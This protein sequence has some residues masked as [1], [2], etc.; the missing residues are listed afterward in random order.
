MSDAAQTLARA[1]APF[2]EEMSRLRPSGSQ[3]V[4]AHAHLGRDEDGREL[5]PAT[6]REML[7]ADDVARAVVFALH[8]PERRPAYSLP[9]DRVL[10][11]AGESEG[12]FVPF[13][14]LDPAD[15]PIAEAERCLERGARGFKLHPRAQAFGFGDGVADEIFALA[16]QAGVPILIHAGRGMPPIADGLA[17]LALRYP[18]APLILAHGAIADQ[19]V[20]TTRLAGHPSVLY[21]TSCFSPYDILALFARAP[22]ERIVFGSDPP[23]GRP[24]TGL[25]MVLRCAAAAGLDEQTLDLVL[26]GTVD[27]MLAGL[28]LPEPTAP[29]RADPVVVSGRL[30]R[31]TAYGAI[32]FGGLIAGS[33][34][35]ARGAVDLMAAAAR[36]P[37]PDAAGEALGRISATLEAAADLF[38]DPDMRWPA[39]GLMHMCLTL[40]ATELAIRP[41]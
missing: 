28:P 21:D 27:R 15:G 22:A 25:Y 32:A 29:R 7:D 16:E 26:G 4:E 23:Y 2:R 31:V 33:V 34:D 3:I 18:G 30:A 14:R 1:A 8:D 13:A 41:R 40:A 36:D 11:W 38:E 35:S 24:I 19:G 37:E 6:L 20:L 9:N 39:F 17:D 10:A 12:R 5:D